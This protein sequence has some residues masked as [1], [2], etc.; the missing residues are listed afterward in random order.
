MPG[1]SLD[2]QTNHPKRPHCCVH[3]QAPRCTTRLAWGG[4][5]G[6]PGVSARSRRGPACCG[7]WSPAA[8]TASEMTAEA[9]FLFHTWLKVLLKLL[10]GQDTPRSRTNQPPGPT[11]LGTHSSDSFQRQ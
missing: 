8:S 5:S 1:C 7:G 6:W 9:R 4:V 2:P 10:S 3:S 11:S